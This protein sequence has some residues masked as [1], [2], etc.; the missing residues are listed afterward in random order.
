MGSG[1]VA[2]VLK[3]TNKNQLQ[4]IIV[5]SSKVDITNEEQIKEYLK[6]FSYVKTYEIV[7]INTAAKINLEFCEK[8]KEIAYKTNVVGALNLLKYCSKYN[9]KFVHISSGCIFDGNDKFYTEDDIPS[10]KAWYTRTKVWAD[11]IITNFGYENYL[12]LRPRQ[13][14][15]SSPNPTNLLTKFLSFNEINAIDESNSITCIEDM[16]RALNFMLENGLTGIFNVVNQGV[17]TPYEIA[18]ALKKIKP[19]LMVNKISYNDFLKT[20]D[21][22]RV[23]TLLDGQKLIDH[24]FDMRYADVA[25]KLCI[26]YYGVNDGKN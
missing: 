2:N 10:P 24:G 13:L 16:C 20:V 22:K 26:K 3:T 9:Y 15:S 8:E 18:L 19:E 11:E 21:V 4:D 23:N 5:P 25:L 7:V 17:C 6:S 1:K 14:I 12:I